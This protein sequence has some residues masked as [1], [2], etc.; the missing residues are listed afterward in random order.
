MTAIK[1]VKVLT[2]DEEK[3]TATIWG[4]FNTKEKLIDCIRYLLD[5]NSPEDFVLYEEDTNRAFSMVET[6]RRLNITSL[7]GKTA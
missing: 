6:A 3:K 5:S 1:T 4:I 7:R 2:L